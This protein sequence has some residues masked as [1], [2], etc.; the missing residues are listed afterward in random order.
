MLN[1]FP[2]EFTKI[3]N[4]AK[5][6]FNQLGIDINE[7]NKSNVSVNLNKLKSEEFFDLLM[8]NEYLDMFTN[9]V[10]RY[11]PTV[12]Y[13]PKRFVNND[14]IINNYLIPK[15][16]TYELNNI[17][18]SQN[19][20]LFIDPTQFVPERW[21]KESDY[22]KQISNHSWKPFGTSPKICLGHK[23]AYLELKVFAIM[24]ATQC[25]FD[26]DENNCNISPSFFNFYHVFA[27]VY[28]KEVKN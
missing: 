6:I 20:Q 17:G 9:E 14:E 1:K 3:E 28:D 25:T 4:E 13:I 26:I 12:R 7:N 27:K 22:Y 11:L 21:N 10:M 19:E 23:L 5:E 2:N 18:L 15:G 24:F 8:N 16:V